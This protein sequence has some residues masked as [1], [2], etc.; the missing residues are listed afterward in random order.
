MKERNDTGRYRDEALAWVVRLIPGNAKKADVEAFERWSAQ[1]PAHARAFVEARRLWEASRSPA[2]DVFARSSLESPAPAN[3]PLI[4]RRALLGGGAV[5]AITAAS[6]LLIQPPFGLWTPILDVIEADYRTGKGE[7]KRLKLADASIELNTDTSVALRP[8]G[9]ESNRVELLAGEGAFTA[10]SQPFEVI[11]GSG[12]ARAS[13]ASFNMRRNGETVFVTCVA[14][15]VQIVCGAA[16]VSLG[17]QQQLA[18]SDRGISNTIA[19]D[20]ATVT[21]WQNGFLVFHDVPL[22][23]VLAEVNRYR[24]GRILLVNSELGN[25]V[26]NARFRLDR[27]DD[28]VTK[29]TNAFGAS[30]TFLPG[31]L[32]ILS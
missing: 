7:Q 22:N 30:A 25:R 27:I 6:Y 4:G 14:G 24:H 32:V 17:A 20:S 28:V 3:R 1:S 5:A 11:A 9:N 16:T 8:R 29:V 13:N 10:G 18:Y 21:A 2:Q 23:E 19:V 31:G 12:H 15:T 26:V